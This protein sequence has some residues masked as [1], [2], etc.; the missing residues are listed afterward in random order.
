MGV[1]PGFLYF[2]VT[3]LETGW[4]EEEIFHYMAANKW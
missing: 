3:K 4:N 1:F 2:S